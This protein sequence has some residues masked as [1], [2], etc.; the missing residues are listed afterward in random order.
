M[1]HTSVHISTI[2]TMMSLIRL[3]DV[4]VP[5]S[6]AIAITQWEPGL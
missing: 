3:A 4:T 6:E 2:Y 5:F 1:L